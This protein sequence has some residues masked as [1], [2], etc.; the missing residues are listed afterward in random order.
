VGFVM[1]QK[2]DVLCW[3]FLDN[4]IVFEKVGFVVFWISNAHYFIFNNIII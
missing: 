4:G 2:G 1:Q 3:I